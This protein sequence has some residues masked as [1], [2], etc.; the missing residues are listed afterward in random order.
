VP[1]AGEVLALAGEEIVQHADLLA[2]TEQ[3]MHQRRTN[4]SCSACHQIKRH[5]FSSEGYCNSLPPLWREPRMRDS[6]SL[7]RTVSWRAWL[8]IS[9]RRL[10]SWCAGF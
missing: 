4:E 9:R 8:S 7:W 10:A 3:L 2:A 1:Q 5:P 6:I